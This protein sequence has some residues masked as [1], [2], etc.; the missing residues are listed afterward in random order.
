MPDLVLLPDKRFYLYRATSLGNIQYSYWH[1]TNLQDPNLVESIHQYL[2]GIDC[3]NIG[4]GSAKNLEFKY[5]FDAIEMKKTIES[6]GSVSIDRLDLETESLTFNAKFGNLPLGVSVG[7]VD[8]NFSQ[9][10]I[11]EKSESVFKIKL[12]MIYLALFNAFFL[13][14]LNKESI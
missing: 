12:P 8:L 6:L 11:P 1:E 3:R 4:I 13:S 14:V 7:K 9:I 10:F 2:F 5:S